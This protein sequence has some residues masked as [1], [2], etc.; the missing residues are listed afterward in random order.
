MGEP[1][2]LAAWHSVGVLSGEDSAGWC[3][4]AAMGKTPRTHLKQVKCSW[5]VVC[6]GGFKCFSCIIWRSVSVW[7]HVHWKIKHWRV[8]YFICNCSF[9]M[10]V[11]PTRVCRYCLI[12]VCDTLL[13]SSETS[14]SAVGDQGLI[15]SWYWHRP[16]CLSF[17]L[18]ERESERKWVATLSGQSAQHRRR[19]TAVFEV[20]GS[21]PLWQLSL[22]ICGT[23]VSDTKAGNIEYALMLLNECISELW[24]Q[25]IIKLYLKL[26]AMIKL[27]LNCCH[28]ELL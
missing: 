3:V 19:L 8:F 1:F 9:A 12:S 2:F 24:L 18:K 13:P 20:G 11:K 5:R 4:W 14:D 7:C 16:S 15:P 25:A 22:L 27:L 28:C 23:F 10:N 6:S 21:I 26:F 17:Y